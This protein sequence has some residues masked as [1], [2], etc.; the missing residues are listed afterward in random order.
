MTNDIDRRKL[1]RILNLF[2]IISYI[3]FFASFLYFHVHFLSCSY[4]VHVSYTFISRILS[5]NLSYTVLYFYLHSYTFHIRYS[6]MLITFYVL[7]HI[8]FLILYLYHVSFHVV[9]IRPCYTIH[10]LHIVLSYIFLYDHVLSYTFISSCTVILYF[11]IFSFCTFHILYFPMIFI[12][13]VFHILYF[14]IICH[15]HFSVIDTLF[16]VL[17]YLS[18]TFLFHILYLFIYFSFTVLCTF[19]ILSYTVLCHFH[20]LV[21]ILF[22]Y[23]TLYFLY[24]VIYNS[25]RFMSTN[26]LEADTENNC[27]YP[28]V[29]SMYEILISICIYLK[30]SSLYETVTSTCMTQTGP[31]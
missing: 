4:I 11:P 31:L 24:T 15:I 30:V 19:H 1:N 7:L 8:S 22:M 17:V 25:F 23:C 10:F 26:T 27:M 28:K 9:A 3:I 12:Y 2:H 20:I 13:C 29:L 5:Y 21:H 18:Y 16:L 6:C 14:H